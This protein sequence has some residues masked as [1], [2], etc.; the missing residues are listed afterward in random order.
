[1]PAF[2][3]P[4]PIAATVE[5]AGAQVRVGASERTDTVVLVEPVN[6]A[7]KS[8]VRVAEGTKVDFSGGRLTVKTTVP[9]SKNGSVAISID[10]PA[11]SSLAASVA[12][13]SLHADG[14]L[15]ECELHM[16]SG[17]VQLDSIGALQANIAA[18]EVAVGHIAGRASIDGGTATVRIGE[19][20]GTVRLASS[21][22]QLWIGEARADLDLTNG[23]GGFD[24]DRADGGVTAKTG[25]GAIRIGRLTRGQAELV[26]GSGNIEIG[27]SEGSAAQV[28]ANSERG[29]VRNSVPPQEDP[30]AFENKVTVHARTRHGDITIHRAGTPR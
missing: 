13:S 23:S 24:I 22:G 3:R 1:M 26:N 20:E 27:I 25:A 30:G 5:V 2:T 28:D 18:G 7:S 10:L 6:K 9:G 21:A 16:A 11:G 12:N 8:D 29:T 17:Q 14:P 4:G 15:G 19:V